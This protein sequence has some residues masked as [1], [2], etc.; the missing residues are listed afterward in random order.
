VKI[1]QIL[2]KG[3]FNTGS[4]HQMFALAG[5]LADRGHT[6]SVAGK[7]GSEVETACHSNHIP[8]VP[9]PFRLDFDPI[10][11]LGL[12]RAFR[13]SGVDV[14]HVHKGRPHTLAL[15]ASMLVPVPCFVANRGVS[16]PL[17][18]WNRGKYRSRRCHRVVCVCDAIR[19]IVIRSGKLPPEKVVTIYAGTDLRR[20]DPSREDGRGLRRELGFEDHHVV[21]CQT[22]LREWRGWRTLVEAFAEIAPSAPEARLLLVAAK[23]EEHRRMIQ[24]ET[25]RLHITGR[26][27]IL[28]YR[29]DMPAIS[30]A[31]D[32]A[33]D[34]SYAGLGIT[35]T[36]REGM[37]MGRPV[38]ASSAGGNPELVIE[39]ETGFLV[40]PGDPGSTGKALLRLIR[41]PDE[42]TRMG[43]AGRKRV[44][45]FFSTDIRVSRMERLYSEVVTSETGSSIS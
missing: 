17:T 19:D 27:V 16:F 11:I 34:F 43:L 5:S 18:I 4:V 8:Y 37:A 29:S 21:V 35:G 28:G 2:D 22:G 23:D 30:A 6:V 38:V 39:G 44:V 31:Q 33:C 3:S 45:D 14:V 12:A 13:H 24:T 42:R 20:F 9:L 36:L 15:L 41:N 26:T 32:I 25:D 40:P 10:T 1:F 7:P